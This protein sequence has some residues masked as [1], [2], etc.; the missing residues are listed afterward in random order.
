MKNLK[1]KKA[2]ASL[3]K[4]RE[5]LNIRQINLEASVKTNLILLKQ[6]KIK[7]TMSGSLVSKLDAQ[8]LL[9]DIE[10]L[11]KELES[12]KKA[13]ET[14]KEERQASYKIKELELSSVQKSLKKN[15]II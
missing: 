4:T 14:F 12:S 13:L 9:L 7:K 3:D 6:A 2:Q 8:K 1:K 11:N 15:K 5:E 10:K